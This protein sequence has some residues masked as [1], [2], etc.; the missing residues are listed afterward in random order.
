[1]EDKTIFEELLERSPEQKAEARKTDRAY[2]LLSQGYWSEA[3]ALFDEIL[4]DEPNNSEAL[5]GKRLISRQARINR[6]MDSL[7][8]RAYKTN[9]RVKGK[10]KNPLRNKAVLW[11]VVVLFLLCCGFA[12]A[13]VAGVLPEALDFF[14]EP[15]PVVTEAL[16]TT[17]PTPTP[18]PTENVKT[19]DEIYNEYM[20]GISQ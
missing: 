12:A 18:T 13:A 1:M 19:A 16:P 17:T 20:N 9:A 2:H 7:D 11:V 6:R 15:K 8:A 5:M 3:D 4:A 14:D 10:S